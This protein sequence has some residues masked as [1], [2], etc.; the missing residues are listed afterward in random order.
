MM[1]RSLRGQFITCRAETLQVPRAGWLPQCWP[2][3]DPMQLSRG[4]WA[5]PWDE[6]KLWFRF[7]CLLSVAKQTYGILEMAKKM[8]YG[9]LR[10]RF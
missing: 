3:T 1:P 7:Q 10:A 4:S 9:S 5:C 6:I 8:T 2:L